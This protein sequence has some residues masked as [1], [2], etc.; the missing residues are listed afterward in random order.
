MVVQF[1]VPCDIAWT[2]LP[3][4]LVYLPMLQQLVLDVA[5]SRNQ[6]TI[7]VGQDFS[8]AMDELSDPIPA[9]AS[10][11]ENRESSLSL[12]LP[13]GSEV[14]L[15]PPVEEASPKVTVSTE[16]GPGLYRL[17]HAI[18][19]ENEPP[20]VT[21]V[22][23]VVEVPAT[24]SRLASADR[25]RLENAAKAVGGQVYTDMQQLQQD[26]RTRRYGREVWRWL[27]FGLLIV[28]VAEL[29]VQQFAIR[30]STGMA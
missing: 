14:A 27:L 3:T 29:L 19:L 13:D 2:N 4:R 21:R 23:R 12:E 22:R 1:A 9:D 6:T 25:T 10:T 7:N 24:E 11:D 28:M 8:V 20:W 15:K 18:P 30:A 17:R 26:D 16:S 5:G